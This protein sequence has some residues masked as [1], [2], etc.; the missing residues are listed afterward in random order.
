M[1][2][3]SLALIVVAL[4]GGSL[5]VLLAIS[6]RPRPAPT[7]PPAAVTTSAVT[8]NGF[9]LTSSSMELPADEAMYPPGPNVDLVNQRCLAC[10]SP[11]MALV[12]PALKPEQ[13]KAIVEKMRDVY[14][15]PL[16]PGEVAPIVDYFAGRGAAGA[17]PAS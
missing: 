16:E 6:T 2:A 11:S 14:H 12:Q 8:A 7:A 4:I 17:K 10:H 3:P 13:W 9:T 1:R 15:A 5:L